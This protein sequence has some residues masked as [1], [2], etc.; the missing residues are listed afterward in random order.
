MGDLL[1]VLDPLKTLHTQHQSLLEE[2]KALRLDLQ[3]A[4]LITKIDILSQAL[5]TLGVLPG[6]HQA[7]ILEVQGVRQDLQ[8]KAIPLPPAPIKP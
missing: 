4:D 8:K 2:T 7:L 3:K 5:R 1:T 6:Q